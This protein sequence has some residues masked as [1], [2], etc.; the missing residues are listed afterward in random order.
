MCNDCNARFHT[1]FFSVGGN[2]RSH[3]D[4]LPLAS[5]PGGVWPGDEAN[6]PPSLASYTQLLSS[7]D[8]LQCS[9][10]KVI[11]DLCWVKLGSEVASGPN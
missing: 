10:C 6:A 4:M 11:R 3:G 7:T 2:A 8:R 9:Y 1:E 5:S